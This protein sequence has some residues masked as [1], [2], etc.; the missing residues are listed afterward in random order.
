MLGYTWSLLHPLLLFVILYLVFVKFLKIGN[1][2]QHY[3]VYLLLGI[4]IWNFFN[5]TTLQSLSSIVGRGDLIR[6]V[7]IPRWIIVL[8]SS[9][10][11]LI[12]LFLNLVV[13][14]IF[15]VINH[16]EIY[17]TIVLLPVILLEV[18]VFALGISLFLSAAF[19]KFR[20]VSYI[21]EVILQAGFYI[22]PVI[23]PL[24]RITN[25]TLQKIIMINPMGQAMQDARYVAVTH[26]ST[27]IYQVFKHGWYELIPF[28]IVLIVSFI[29]VWYFRSQSKY[30]A[31]N[32]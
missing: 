30:F 24:S 15:M 7:S 3:P 20:D 29:G 9:I 17:R 28:L 16:V 27:T 10:S 1:G 11:A 12:N 21:W 2:V 18:Y 23:Y 32:I 6:K 26:Q 8:S 19:V 22:T 31:E 13:V 14:G 5:E 25:V 4:V